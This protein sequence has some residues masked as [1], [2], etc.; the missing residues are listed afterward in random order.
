MAVPPP[1]T[2]LVIAYAYLWQHEH[3]AGHEE[4]HKNRP[5]VIVLSIPQRDAT[6]VTV[7]PI[8][9]RP[10]ENLDWAVEIPL[11]IKRHLGLDDERSW[12]IVAEGNQFLWPGYDLRKVPRTSRYS[13]GF[14]PPRFFVHVLEAFRSLHR[15]GN[16]R[17]TPRS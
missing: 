9:H 6:M 12:V 17:L 1:E 3:L 5:A 14:V 13:Y 15:T 10:P 8:T 4:G 16:V 7:L 2:G 11:P